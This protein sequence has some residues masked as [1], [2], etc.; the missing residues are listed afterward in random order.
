M[1]FILVFDKFEIKIIQ[2]KKQKKKTDGI[3]DFKKLRIIANMY[4]C[5][6]FF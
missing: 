2:K 3:L 1:L 5:S 4:Y 6:V